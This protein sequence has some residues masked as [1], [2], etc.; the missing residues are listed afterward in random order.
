MLETKYVGDKFSIFWTK[1]VCFVT[2]P[3]NFFA[4]SRLKMIQ[5]SVTDIFEEKL[6]F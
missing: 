5:F 2:N 6:W 4:R 3:L 1:F